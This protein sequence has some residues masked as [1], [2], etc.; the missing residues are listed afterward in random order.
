MSN[1]TKETLIILKQ[2]EEEKLNCMESKLGHFLDNQGDTHIHIRHRSWQRNEHV[3]NTA[4]ISDLLNRDCYLRRTRE[5][6]SGNESG[7]S[8]NWI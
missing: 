4:R 3:Q 6:N 2:K 1:C 7:Y 8:K 5:N